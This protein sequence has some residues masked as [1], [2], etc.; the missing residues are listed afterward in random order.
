MGCARDVYHDTSSVV[1]TCYWGSGGYTS[2]FVISTAKVGAKY[3][4]S[5]ISF[6]Q[7]CKNARIYC[8]FCVVF[9]GL[10]FL[11]VVVPHLVF[12]VLVLFYFC[13]FF[14]GV[15]SPPN[16]PA[17][18]LTSPAPPPQLFTIFTSPPHKLIIGPLV[19]KLGLLGS[20]PPQLSISG[21]T[22]DP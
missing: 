15:H 4:K 8:D 16:T 5:K 12:D 2:R 10:K 3:K 9:Q 7:K 11:G 1:G 21:F 17:G 18:G 14:C 13:E 20:P 19:L 22:L 6:V